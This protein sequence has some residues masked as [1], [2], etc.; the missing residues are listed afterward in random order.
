MPRLTGLITLNAE[1]DSDSK[2]H[3]QVTK[4]LLPILLLASSVVVAQQSDNR[5]ALVFGPEPAR[6]VIVSQ[7]DAE[8]QYRRV[9]RAH[10]AGKTLTE[11][12]QK[13][14]AALTVAL[15]TIS[16]PKR[17]ETVT[18]SYGDFFRERFQRQPLQ[19]DFPIE[20]IRI[21]RRGRR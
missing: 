5:V 8:R 14:F 15:G 16:D 12:E 19:N 10:E 11:D 9:R 1:T 17:T 7:R 20:S 13:L 4:L 6:I 3:T 2:G 21:R 18:L